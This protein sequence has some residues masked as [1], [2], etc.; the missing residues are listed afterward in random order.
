MLFGDGKDDP[1]NSPAEE[2]PAG[3]NESAITPKPVTIDAVADDPAILPLTDGKED[4][5]TIMGTLSRYADTYGVSLSMGN[6][7]GKGDRVPFPNPAFTSS[8]NAIYIAPRIAVVSSLMEATP[9]A[10]ATISV[11][12][13]YVNVASSSGMSYFGYCDFAHTII[14]LDAIFVNIV[15]IVSQL[16]EAGS[17]NTESSSSMAAVSSYI[18]TIWDLVGMSTDASFSEDDDEEGEK[19]LDNDHSGEL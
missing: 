14:P 18:N 4:D 2:A 6:V 19:E 5:I 7:S 1:D 8:I 9:D 17:D 12:S 10:D 3:V 11:I 16:M 13:S 15:F